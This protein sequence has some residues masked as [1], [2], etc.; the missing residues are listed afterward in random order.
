MV[1]VNA[2]WNCGQRITSG[3]GPCILFE[4]GSLLDFSHCISQA[5][6]SFWRGCARTTVC[7]STQLIRFWEFP[8]VWPAL[9]PDLKPQFWQRLRSGR[10]EASLWLSDDLFLYALPLTKGKLDFEL[11]KLFPLSPPLRNLA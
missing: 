10:E 3:V 8:S 4:P 9:Y 6:L 11:A 7:S 2:G 1:S 5:S